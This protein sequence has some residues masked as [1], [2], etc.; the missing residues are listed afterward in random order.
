MP[1]QRE[2]P[3][4]RCA[5]YLRILRQNRNPP[6]RASESGRKGSRDGQSR[7]GPK[8]SPA[9]TMETFG[10]TRDLLTRMEAWLKQHP[11]ALV[12][13]AAAVGDY[14]VAPRPGKIPSGQTVL[15]LELRPT[16]KILDQIRTWNSRCFLVSFKAAPPETT[17]TSLEKITSAQLRRSQSDLVFGNVIDSLNEQVVLTDPQ[18]N[19]HFPNRKAGLQALL[20]ACIQALTK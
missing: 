8:G 16:P 17:P 9:A 19:Q 15:Q 5:I 3:S 10:S 7:G 4:I 1:V 20:N 12:V 2:I 18:R 13:H 6:R 14:E 11:G